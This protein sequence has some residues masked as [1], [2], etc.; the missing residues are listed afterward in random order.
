MADPL[1]TP[2]ACHRFCNC[3][4]TV[5][6]PGGRMATWPGGCG[7]VA[8]WP[9]GRVAVA[10]PWPGWPATK[11]AVVHFW[12]GAEPIAPAT[13]NDASTC[14]VVRTC[15]VSAVLSKRASRHSSV[16]FFN[17]STSKGAPSTKQF[18]IFDLEMCFTPQRRALFQ[19]LNFQ[20]RFRH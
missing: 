14:K 11:K 15:G 3:Y 5:V 8:V 13:Q 6:W 12:Q 19:Q 20:K 9:C 16:H 17:S 10:W 7:R 18:P 1:Q 2:H 4:K